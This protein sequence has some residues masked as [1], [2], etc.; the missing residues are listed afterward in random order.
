MI[1]EEGPAVGDQAGPVF[2]GL[3]FVSRFE[4]VGLQ[5]AHPLIRRAV[6]GHMNLGP[7]RTAIA[8]VRVISMLD[9]SNLTAGIRQG[10]NK[11][12]NV[13]GSL[14]LHMR[15]FPFHQPE[16]DGLCPLLKLRSDVTM[17]AVEAGPFQPAFPLMR[18]LV[19]R[20]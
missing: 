14:S 7:D 16:L 12:R 3:V 8:H 18:K 11:L 17:E 9:L 4:T 13:L 5:P 1:T 19:R 15:G 2:N 6:V 20:H 10:L